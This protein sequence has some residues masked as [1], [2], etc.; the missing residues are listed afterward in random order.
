MNLDVLE[1]ILYVSEKSL[2]DKT[3]NISEYPRT[4]K[5]STNEGTRCVEP[6]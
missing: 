6:L 3:Q 5:K 2:V 4:S 1:T